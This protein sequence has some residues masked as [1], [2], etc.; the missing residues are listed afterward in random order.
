MLTVRINISM[1]NKVFS[2]VFELR[3]VSYTDTKIIQG[4]KDE[5]WG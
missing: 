1:T 5:R 3:N 2:F 4:F